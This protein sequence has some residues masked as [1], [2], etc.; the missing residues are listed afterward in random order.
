MESISGSAGQVETVHGTMA[1]SE[2]PY[3]IPGPGVTYRNPVPV[4]EISSLL[5]EMSAGRIQRVRRNM[6]NLTLLGV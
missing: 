1:A 5:S 3:F 6:T 4:A 2:S